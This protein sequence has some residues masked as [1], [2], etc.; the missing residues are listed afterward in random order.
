MN[1]GTPGFLL[2]PPPEFFLPGTIAIAFFVMIG[3]IIWVLKIK[4]T[5][6]NAARTATNQQRMS[7]QG[8]NYYHKSAPQQITHRSTK[9][10]FS[11][12]H[13]DRPVFATGLP[14]RFL[15]LGA[16]GS[17]KS[18]I[19]KQL[20]DGLSR[21]GRAPDSGV[22]RL[23]ESDAG[24]NVPAELLAPANV[25]SSAK[26]WKDLLRSLR[27]QR[28]Q[29]PID[30]VIVTVS[31]AGLTGHDAAPELTASGE[32]I[33][34]KL[35]AM[36]DQFGVCFPVY[37]IITKCDVVR[38]FQTFVDAQLRQ[39]LHEMFGWSNPYT[40]DAPFDPDWV[41]QAFEQIQQVLSSSRTDV[42][43]SVIHSQEF[44]KPPLLDNLFLFPAKFQELQAPLKLLL[45]QI[46]KDAGHRNSLQF[47]G[48]YFS[49]DVARS[50]EASQ[51][52]LH[53]RGAAPLPAFIADLFE[54][55]IFPERGLSR[56]VAD[57]FLSRNTLA[58]AAKGLFTIASVLIFVG[59]GLGYYN[60]TQ[61]Q[62]KTAPRLERITDDLRLK[63]RAL[64]V[65]AAYN[66]IYVAQVLSGR[67]FQSVF[68]PAS[69]IA[70]L[71]K[72][73]QKTMP[74]LFEK[75]VYP[76][77][78][79]ELERKTDALL[80]TKSNLTVL[81]PEA[82]DAYQALSIFTNEMLRHESNLVL[83]NNVVPQ[84]RGRGQDVLALADYL[85]PSALRDLPGRGTS[86][87]DRVVRGSHGTSLE[88]RRWH[89]ATLDKLEGL[90]G[91]V[92]KQK[93]KEE[94]LLT[95]L[96][97][98]ANQINQ[99]E[100]DRMETYQ[101]LVDLKNSLTQTQDL[102]ADPSLQWIAK[103][104]FEV[105]GALNLILDPIFSRL[106]ADNVL[107]CDINPNDQ[108][109]PNLSQLK[110]FTI[111]TGNA[112]FLSFRTNL[113]SQKTEATGEL[114][115]AN[116]GKLQ[117]SQATSSLQPLLDS[118]LK[119]PFVMREGSEHIHEAEAGQQLF[120]DN[121]RLQQAIQDKEAYDKFLEGDLATSSDAIQDTFEEVA[122]DRLEPNMVDS[123]AS[124]QQFQPLAS[125][126]K[127]DQ[128]T[129]AEARN[130]QA[131]FPSLE[132]LLEQFGELSF[133]D[134][135]GDLLRV[136]TSHAAGLLARIDSSFEARR[137]YSPSGNFNLWTSMN[138]PTFA[139]Y[140][141]HNPEEMLGY[142]ALQRQDV[143]QYAALTKPLVTFLQARGT[144]NQ[145]QITL[146][147]KWQGIVSDVQK[148][149]SAPASTGLGSLEELLDVRI[150]KVTPQDC[151]A[152]L[153][154]AS[155]GNAYFV[156]VRRSIERA[157][158][159]RCRSLSHQTGLEQ[160]RQV[161]D[162]FNQHLSGKFPFSPPPKDA[163]EKEAD[164]A[165]VVEFF[166]QLDASSKSIREGMANNGSVGAG[167]KITLFL[168]QIDS[169]RPLFT[170]LFSSQ[171]DPV[172]VVDF[173][174][175]FRVNRN[176]EIGGNE[177]IDWA[178]QV[179]DTTF[180]DSDKQ[181]TGRW[182]FGD[183]VKLVLRWAKDSPNQP[184]PF[185]SKT[186][187]VVGNGTVAFEYN[188]PWSLLTMMV[189]HGAPASDFERLVDPDPQTLVFVIDQ[190]KQSIA[191][192]SRQRTA[193]VKSDD[194]EI[195]T[196]RVFIRAKVYP[197]GKNEAL[198]LPP[199]PTEA[200]TP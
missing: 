124:A 113:L 49:G 61:I 101:Q 36:R 138:T 196:A 144:R 85:D 1:A 42:M 166:R 172:P 52:R 96:N 80:S 154:S 51:E 149:D 28:P 69:I 66:S 111:Q 195:Q 122:L 130:F 184:V 178:L 170:S 186:Y 45:E 91:G 182:T 25:N 183:P 188:D 41:K 58:L 22:S 147:A 87:L 193:V 54:K 14:P 128:A 86:A 142:L 78:R 46:F 151:Q 31:C 175:A 15:L 83:F 24:F 13:L 191:P 110:S 35:R 2:N 174:P 158:Y 168:N 65:P 160:Y 93:V 43:A 164:P 194:G 71:D 179:G 19:F 97:E 106:T 139:G 163:S 18:D 21:Q 44:N 76:G 90:I 57:V 16:S 192:R 156:Q 118:F 120:W 200:P 23:F 12:E 176:R 157:L 133:T 20:R 26:E 115:V 63:D 17:G 162:F 99:L 143:L 40:L 104:S 180:R 126:D 95:S 89:K 171:P 140:S 135:Y 102:L 123:V 159:T 38:G 50:D 197:P 150:D 67:N 39:H 148:Y 153:T 79:S 3:I 132:K 181:K 134:A 185:S 136:S 105:P 167:P 88:T 131:A 199:F 55:K 173:A 127:S 146:I 60:F 7:S 4:N 10:D 98:L 121:D 125:D 5:R 74:P 11:E 9:T 37:V 165:D 64:N 70:S 109:C 189:Q 100:Q 53:Q 32:R 155:T 94:R 145:K 34:E 27:L 169:L 198:R 129:A 141:A 8:T 59:T 84:E 30:G 33:A 116:S 114:I 187:T 107:L 68:L 177:I 190:Q 72:D 108:P 103:D 81:E 47:R 82:P 117:F 62:H 137:L 152:V 77:L 6:A 112:N 73:V 161:A 48:I 92:F 29:R 119:I 75:L 56:P